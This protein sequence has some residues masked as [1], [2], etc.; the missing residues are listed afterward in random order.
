MVA[1]AFNS[2]T[3]DVETVG[4]LSL[5]QDSQGFYMEKTFLKNQKKGGVG[6][7]NDQKKSLHMIRMD[8][9]PF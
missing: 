5:F 8:A 1:H 7:D 2:S 3:Q 9:F 6:M 4:A